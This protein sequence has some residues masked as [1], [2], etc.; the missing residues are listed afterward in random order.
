MSDATKT[1]FKIDQ[2]YHEANIFDQADVL[3][4][5]SIETSEFLVLTQDDTFD[6]ETPGI[7]FV[8][9]DGDYTVRA[10]LVRV[11]GP[12]EC[13]GRKITIACRRLEFD[14]DRQLRNPAL[15]VDGKAGEDANAPTA[16]VTDGQPGT[17]GR[18]QGNHFLFDPGGPRWEWRSRAE[19]NERGRKW[20]R[21][22]AVLP[23]P[24]DTGAHDAE[25]ERRR[26]RFGIRTE[27]LQERA[28]T[29]TWLRRCTTTAAPADLAAPAGRAARGR[30]AARAERSP[31]C[32]SIWRGRTTP[33][34]PAR[35][36]LGRI[37]CAAAN[38]SSGAIPVRRP[39]DATA[40]CTSRAAASPSIE[41]AR[42]TS[43]R[44]C[45]RQVTH[46]ARSSRCRTMA[47]WSVRCSA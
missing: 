15:I 24:G 3:V 25:R 38:R 35:R 34:T 1:Q 5:A 30:T 28:A 44:C 45:G 2:N 39:T 20:R 8:T 10:S 31:C 29:A 32:T 23:D 4:S 17:G 16:L 42:T 33:T 47:T 12:I 7:C 26:G 22:R 11:C 19:R 18:E 27:A 21:D 36:R 37:A 41:T 43:A 14:I 46:A 9:P 13:P 40:S 6:P